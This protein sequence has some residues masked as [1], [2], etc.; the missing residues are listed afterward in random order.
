M[1]RVALVTCLGALLL[2]FIAIPALA[3]EIRGEN[4][5]LFREGSFTATIYTLVPMGGK[6]L[7][8]TG[9]IGM[10]GSGSF[11]VYYTGF[12]RERNLVYLRSWWEWKGMGVFSPPSGDQILIVPY[13]VDEPTRLL[14]AFVP[15]KSVADNTPTLE[16]EIQGVDELLQLRIGQEIKFVLKTDK[17]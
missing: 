6:V 10:G 7:A 8:G 17:K 9:M 1:R 5:V 3:E 16:L 11:A 13:K 12:D 15:S 4:I 14:L 2:T